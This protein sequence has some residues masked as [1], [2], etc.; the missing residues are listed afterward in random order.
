MPVSIPT[1][2]TIP[3]IRTSTRLMAVPVLRFRNFTV[4]HL[5]LAAAGRWA[6]ARSKRA[7]ERVAIARVPA[8]RH[9]LAGGGVVLGRDLAARAVLVADHRVA[10]QAVAPGRGSSRAQATPRRAHR[11]GDRSGSR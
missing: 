10:A 6:P 1:T 5:G 2:A 3:P 4:H 9:P 8:A 7:I 11:T